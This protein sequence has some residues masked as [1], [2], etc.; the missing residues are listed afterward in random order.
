MS[1]SEDITVIGAGVTGL[2]TSLLLLHSG[3]SV[4]VITADDPKNEQREPMFVSQYPSA[5]VIPH[6]F[7]SDNKHKQLK[8]SLSFFR[9]FWR[10][11]VPGISKHPHYEAFHKTLSP[12]W[13]TEWMDDFS[14]ISV[15]E[16]PFGGTDELDLQT[17]WMFSCY[18]ADWNTYYPRLLKAFT[19]AGGTLLNKRLR[20]EDLLSLPSDRIINCSELGS[21]ALFPE[22]FPSVQLQAGHL[23]YVPDPSESFDPS[24]VISYN[25]TPS[26]SVHGLDTDIPMDVYSYRRKDGWVLGGSRIP[27]T[28]DSESGIRSKH[29]EMLNA[30]ACPSP[31]FYLNREII[32]SYY[33]TDLQKLNA[34]EPRMSYRMVQAG[35]AGLELS[36]SEM[37]DKQIIHNVGHG[38]A[39]VTMSW[40]C[41]YE[42][43][44]LIDPSI[45]PAELLCEKVALSF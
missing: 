39:G 26:A 29:S 18:F 17:A 42:A 35:P 7:E 27:A 37:K 43:C 21:P 22:Q 9:T 32:L 10:Q 16:L 30:E 1:H 5:S 34:P 6:S 19:D 38:G 12:Y 45:P 3:F 31:V 33:N 40:G 11:G 15:D 14:V 36:V 23:L 20:R 41:A 8:D 28:L 25:I 4:T 44:R 13:Y 24:S 2:S